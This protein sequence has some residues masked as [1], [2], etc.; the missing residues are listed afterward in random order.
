MAAYL[1]FRK[2]ISLTDHV[3]WALSVANVS[4]SSGPCPADQLWCLRV[5]LD[6]RLLELISAG[7]NVGLATWQQWWNMEVSNKVET[8]FFLLLSVHS[9]DADDIC[10]FLLMAVVVYLCHFGGQWNFLD[11][12]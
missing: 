3:Y 4:I 2:G 9:F 11:V 8:F 7:G 5:D 12:M 10:G 6:W 1:L